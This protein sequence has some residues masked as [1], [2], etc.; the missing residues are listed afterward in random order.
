M[1]IKVK[2]K[3]LKSFDGTKI[4]YQVIGNGKIPFV[5][6]NGLG[7]T[8]HTWSPLYENLSKKFTFITWDY[9]GIFTS[10][11]PQDLSHLTIEHHCKDLEMVLKKEKITK[12]IF[13]GWSMGVQVC[14]E[15]YRKHA[16]NFKGLFLINGTYGYVLKTALNSPLTKYILPS[17]NQLIIKMMPTL[18]PKLQPLAKNVINSKDFLSII[19]KLGLVHK[20]FD[21]EIFTQLAHEMM[22]TNLTAYHS[23]MD[24]II[25][26][27]ASDVLPQIKVP[28][29]I[30][31]ST[32][33]IITPSHTAEYMAEQIPKAELFIVNEG[34]HYSL[35][36][37]PEIITKRVQQFLNETV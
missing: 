11:A 23:I 2:Q 8:S 10:E 7:G 30:I 33:D 13:G 3:H 16:K 31:S 15:Y 22:D 12:A 26:H 27:D 35:L 36:E 6:C 14:L 20:N 17:I 29:L 4:G 28:T 34:S 9:R 1:P 21:S 32:K 37:F 19:S 18:Q 24:C 5:L 25:G